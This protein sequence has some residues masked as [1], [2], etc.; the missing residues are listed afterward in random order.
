MK[1]GGRAFTLIELLVVIAIIAILAALLLPALLGAKCMAERLQCV[2]NQKQI[3]VA[4]FSY[5]ES[6]NGLFPFIYAGG[7]S[8]GK[9]WADRVHNTG[10]LLG[11]TNKKKATAYTC[12]DVLK[13]DIDGSFSTIGNHYMGNTE[14]M[15]YFN[16]LA[17]PTLWNPTYTPCHRILDPVGTILIGDAHVRTDVDPFNLYLTINTTNKTKPQLY[18]VGLNWSGNQDRTKAAFVGY[19][20]RHRKVPVGLFAD[21]HVEPKPAPWD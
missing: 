5:V 21:G 6:Y 15:G 17:S 16:D 18:L 7:G 12:P 3:A 10:I 11:S 1:T 9:S 14:I 4:L 2:N 8:E 20:E 13:R 19:Y